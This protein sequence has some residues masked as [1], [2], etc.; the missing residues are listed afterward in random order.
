MMLI[1]ASAGVGKSVIAALLAA[2]LPE[3]A[4]S[5]FC[6]QDEGPVR[7]RCEGT[8]SRKMVHASLLASTFAERHT[9]SLLSS[10]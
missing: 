10:V 4:A 1:S 7:R 2:E 5:H 9:K 3:V 6:R 8:R